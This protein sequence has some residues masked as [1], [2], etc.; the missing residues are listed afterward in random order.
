M[1]EL[2]P[3]KGININFYK[4]EDFRFPDTYDMDDVQERIYR[5]NDNRIEKDN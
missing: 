3:K 4:F 1:Y 2:F 5:V